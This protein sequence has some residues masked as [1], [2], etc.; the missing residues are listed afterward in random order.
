M[1]NHTNNVNICY[2]V[3]FTVSTVRH[4]FLFEKQSLVSSSVLR[5]DLVEQLCAQALDLLCSSGSL[6]ISPV[7][8]SMWSL[9][10]R[11]SV[12]LR[13]ALNLLYI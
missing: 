3:V 11:P 9:L 6:G 5:L 1:L 13:W 2:A 8:C 4:L 10:V 7:T 12:A